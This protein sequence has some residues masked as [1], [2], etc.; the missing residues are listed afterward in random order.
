MWGVC[1]CVP[2]CMIS[3]RWHFHWSVVVEGFDFSDRRGGYKATF[4]CAKEWCAVMYRNVFR[5]CCSAVHV[6]IRDPGAE[7]HWHVIGKIDVEDANG[8]LET[9]SSAL[10]T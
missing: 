4:F 8:D 5:W 10:S 3:L 7:M 9:R 2:W 1:E 6:L